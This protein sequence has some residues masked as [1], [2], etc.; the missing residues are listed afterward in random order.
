MFKTSNYQITGENLMAHEI[1]GLNAK[2]IGSS[3]KSRIGIK[4]KVVDETMNTLV[5]DSGKE[6]KTF[7]K[8]E[9]ELRIDLGNES[10]DLDGKLIVARPEDRTK[11]F[12]RKYHGRVQ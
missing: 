3:D 8:K 9:I 7:P 2:V 10:V 4:G 1:I 5:I 11:L 12:W 6:E